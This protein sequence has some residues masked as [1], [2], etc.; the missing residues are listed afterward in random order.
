MPLIVPPVRATALLAWV[1]I[2]PSP[3]FVRAALAV[4]AFVPP[5]A[6]AMGVATDT[7]GS[8]N[9]L[10]L[11]AV[12]STPVA[13][14]KPRVTDPEIAIYAIS[15]LAFSPFAIAS[16]L[17]CLKLGHPAVTLISTWQP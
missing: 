1:A 9:S 3:R 8:P 17:T 15:L 2:V 10:R 5:L 16:T 14:V 12:I 4:V 7:V 6:I 11:A 13:Y